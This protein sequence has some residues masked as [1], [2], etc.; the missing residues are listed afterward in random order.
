MAKQVLQY[1]REVCNHDFKNAEVSPTTIQLTC[2]GVTRACIKKI[3]IK[4][5][6]YV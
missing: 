2:L 1:L 3:R 4:R 5:V 6:C